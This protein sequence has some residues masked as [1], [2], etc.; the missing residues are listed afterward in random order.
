MRN[1]EKRRQERGAALATVLL[2]AFLLLT[3]SVMLLSGVSSA[4]RNGTDMLSETKAFYAAES[5][6]QATINAL[7]HQSPKVKYS[8]A[9][10]N[11]TMDSHGIIYNCDAGTAN[12]KVAI[13]TTPNCSADAYRISVSDPDNYGAGLSFNTNDVQTKF[14]SYT[15]SSGTSVITG[16]GATSTVT[17]TA[18]TPVPTATPEPTPTPDP[19]PEPTPV[20]TAVPAQQLVI[21]MTAKPNTTI[22]YDGSPEIPALV[23][24]SIAYQGTSG[25]MIPD[26][27][28]INFQIV[29]T[30][31]AP[32]NDNPKKTIFGKIVKAANEP[33]KITLDSPN[34]ELVGS[35][36]T[37]CAPTAGA[38][39]T[40]TPIPLVV[41]EPAAA[42][43]PIF[44]NIT[45]VEPV[46]LLVKSTGFGPF[47]AKKQLEAILRKDLPN[48]SVP[49]GLHT[50]V[51]GSACPAD[52]PTCLGFS[53][54]AGTSNG[55]AYSGCDPVTGVCVPSFILT[56][57]SNYN[58]VST[59]PPS[60]D[61][62]Q[63][64]PPPQIS[65]TANLPAWQQSP[66][67]LDAFVDEMR[68]IAQ[69]SDR[70]FRASDGI[71]PTVVPNNPGDFGTG[72]GITFCEGS[73]QV[74]GSGGG[75]MVV[76]GKLTNTGNFSFRGL[77]VVT[78]EEGWLRNGGG[79]G[80]IIGNVV[81]APY[82]MRNYV[83]ENLHL[84]S[85]LPPRYQITGGGGSDIIAG[86][87]T[88]AFA[89]TSG[90]SDIV[91]GIVEK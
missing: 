23:D 58:Y 60:G 87:I 39:C 26:G 21:T 14:T 88:S 85:F 47:G 65:T 68:T 33:L 83:P 67:A 41:T 53:F 9:V 52:Y 71:T 30:L 28:Q 69:G 11:P 38:N 81:I 72:T 54:A 37:F 64:Q 50:M 91:Q 79:N 3:A 70:Y 75:V 35:T 40:Y 74:G 2:I 80:Q 29:Y 56:D 78:G 44:G 5:G 51:G 63:M 27:D 12:E 84:S 20:P 49:P 62:A 42:P 1:T 19:A 18:P 86:D 57:N 8:E 10:A 4:A 7:R 22:T 43:L 34:A 25:A 31:T 17:Y 82:N 46:R 24:F 90:V 48:M 32:R 73:C 59:H 66:A 55:I 15:P 36:I 16:S 77:I 89:T 13:G 61:P 6:L 45:P 76:T